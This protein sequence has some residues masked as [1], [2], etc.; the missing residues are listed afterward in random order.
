[1]SAQVPSLQKNVGTDFSAP[2]SL[3]R[4]I[5]KVVVSGIQVFIDIDYLLGLVFVVGIRSRFALTGELDFTPFRHSDFVE[6]ILGQKDFDQTDQRDQ[7]RRVP[8]H[9]G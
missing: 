9:I 1:M 5:K 2:I 7:D 8:N 6:K 4:F 3:R